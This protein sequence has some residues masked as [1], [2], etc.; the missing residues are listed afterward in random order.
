MNEPQQEEPF[1][2]GYLP[3]APVET[4]RFVRKVVM[5]VALLALLAAGGAAVALPY[6]GNGEFRFGHP[7]EFRGVLRCETASRLQS[8]GEEYLLVGYGKNRVAPEICGAAGNE[9][10]L[11]G[12]LIR[13]DGRQLL[14][15]A[16]SPTGG[17][18]AAGD[19]APPVR[20]G[21]YTLR[22]EIVDSKCYFGVMNP[23][24]GRAHRACAELCLRGGVPAVFVARDRTGAAIHLLIAGENG[25]PINDALLRWVA[26]PVE[27]TGEVWRQGRW[28]V[29]RLNAASLKRGG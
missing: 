17:R 5:G 6:F 27:A 2:V 13:R 28:L 26:E 19:E 18:R 1:Y 24:E 12:T 4:A 9:V 3:R 10:V 21:Q 29:W 25:E 22:G 11:R 15:V 16:S 14:E 23:A 8:G 20:L 7:Q